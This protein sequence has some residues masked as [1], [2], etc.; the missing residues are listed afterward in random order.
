MA[1]KTFEQAM[2]QLERIVQDLESGDMPLEKAIKT[3]EE[4]IQL[5][6]FCSEKL[7][8]TEKRITILLQDAEGKPS[9]A[10]FPACDDDAIS[11]NEN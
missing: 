4:G 9:E 11:E 2:K 6:R 10:P 3:F 8:E 1:K 5:S 7:D